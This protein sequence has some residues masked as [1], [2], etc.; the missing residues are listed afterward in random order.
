MGFEKGS[1]ENGPDTDEA[2]YGRYLRERREEDLRVLLERHR[3]SLTLFLYGYVRNMEDA[4]ELMLD[5]YAAAASG[6]THF[7]GKS[8]FRTWLFAI[9]RNLARKHLR[10]QRIRGVPLPENTAEQDG[11]SGGRDGSP[12]PV[13]APELSM[14]HRERDRRLYQ[15]MEQLNPDY[16]QALYLMYFE[17]M[18]ADEAAQVM[19]RNR[20]QIYNLTDR[21]RKALRETLE[22]MGFED[23]DY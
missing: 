1:F 2:L 16:R 3:E 14:L 18:T 7:S 17:E 13:P 21:G 22:K 9:G 11:A 8:T 10:K 5:A 12:A 20:K 4:E 15:A 19:D 23:E 6:V